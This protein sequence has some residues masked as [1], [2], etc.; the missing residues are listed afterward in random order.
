MYADCGK[1]TGKEW[2]QGE[3]QKCEARLIAEIFPKSGKSS[4]SN[5]IHQTIQIPDQTFSTANARSD[6]F[7]HYLC[8]CAPV[9]RV[10]PFFITLWGNRIINRIQLNTSVRVRGYE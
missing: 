3:P 9:I 8:T 5:P 1:K 6:P 7:F 10:D 2:E 4:T